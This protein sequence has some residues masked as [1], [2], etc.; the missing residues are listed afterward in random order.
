MTRTLIAA[1]LDL[2]TEAQELRHT[3]G[4]STSAGSAQTVSAET[5]LLSIDAL[6]AEV[7][8][9]LPAVQAE[10]RSLSA[11]QLVQI[12]LQQD[13]DDVEGRWRDLV[14]DVD[15]LREE[16]KEDRWLGQ[17]RTAA[18]QATGMMASLENAMINLQVSRRGSSNSIQRG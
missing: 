13:F 5:A 9:A 15:E 11:G 7:S 2:S 17:F 16:L 12:S 1:P 3:S 10:V 4:P 14:A 8:A 18:S 6:L